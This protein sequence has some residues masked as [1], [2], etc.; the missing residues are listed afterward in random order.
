VQAK[1]ALGP[2]VALVVEGAR[3]RTQEAEI[4]T[5]R[6]A[7]GDKVFIG[8]DMGETAI[9][10]DRAAVPPAD[11]SFTV[12]QERGRRGDSEREHDGDDETDVESELSHSDV[13]SVDFDISPS[14]PVHKPIPPPAPPRL[15][16][17]SKFYHSTKPDVTIEKVLA[18]TSKKSFNSGEGRK[19]AT[20]FDFYWEKMRLNQVTTGDVEN[21][22]AKGNKLM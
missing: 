19:D 6:Q 20:K 1:P 13:E 17:W 16:T 3:T 5:S 15:T 14:V 22:I 7:G 9:I 4:I 8:D 2:E 21:V 11:M 10:E 18:D 12:A